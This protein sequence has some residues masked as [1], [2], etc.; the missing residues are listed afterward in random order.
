MG[1]GDGLGAAG[2]PGAGSAAGDAAPGA[3]GSDLLAVMREHAI[4]AGA[5]YVRTEIPGVDFA[6]DPKVVY[7]ADLAYCGRT[8]VVATGA[9]GRTTRVPGEERLLGHGVSYCATCDAPLVVAMDV[10]VIGDSEVAVEEALFLSRFASTVH[11][12][13]STRQLRVDAEMTRAVEADDKIRVHYGCELQEV[14]GE[15]GVPSIVVSTEGRVVSLPMQGAF[16]YLTGVEPTTAFLRGTLP[17]TD[18]GCVETDAEKATAI[19]G[20]TPWG[21]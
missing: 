16:V 2:L 18:T 15:A 14:V 6:S 8:V 3:T 7:T 1:A 5:D 4:E 21:T 10:A 11:L 9:L 19:A 20:A 17:L 12:I 13:A